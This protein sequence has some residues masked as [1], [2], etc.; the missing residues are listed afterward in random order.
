MFLTAESFANYFTEALR[1]HK[2][3]A[4]R[5]RFRGV[6]VLLVDDVSF[7]GAKRVIQEEFLHTIKQLE[8]HHAR[9][10]TA[11]PRGSMPRFPPKPAPLLPSA[12]PTACAS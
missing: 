3:P 1:E 2:L 9:L 10:S 6:D 4:F 5:R 12:S 11:A 8:S 7:L